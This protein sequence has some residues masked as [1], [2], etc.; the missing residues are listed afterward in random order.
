MVVVG[1]DL[2]LASVDAAGRVDLVGRELR[3]ERNGG[4]RDRLRLRITPMRIGSLLWACAAEPTAKARTAAP[5]KSVAF[6]RGARKTR[7][8]V[9]FIAFLPEL[10]SMPPRECPQA[11]GSG[12][13]LRLERLLS[14]DCNAFNPDGKIEFSLILVLWNKIAPTCRNTR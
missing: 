2:D 9:C 1:D 5:K 12:H 14:R 11:K 6:I 13:S 3:A 8:S 10:F 4:S 7:Q